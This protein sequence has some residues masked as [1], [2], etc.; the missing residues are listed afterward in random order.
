MT[1]A[2]GKRCSRGLGV[3]WAPVV[4]PSNL[5]HFASAGRPCVWDFLSL[6]GFKPSSHNFPSLGGYGA[7]TIVC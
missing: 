5:R 4:P 1:G 7:P 3:D 2:R 6:L